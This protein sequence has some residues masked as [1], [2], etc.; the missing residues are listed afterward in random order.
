MLV[1]F[2]GCSG[3][4]SIDIPASV[5]DMGHITFSGC[6][7]LTS[8]NIPASVTS[9]GDCVFEGCSR[10]TSIDIPANVTTIGKNAFAGCSSL[11]SIDIPASVINIEE[12][13]LKDCSGLTLLN[14]QEGVI[15]IGKFRVDGCTS[16][17]RINIPASV[18]NI[19]YGA[20]ASYYST[21]PTRGV[22][23]IFC[24]GS[25]PVAL[26]GS[27]FSSYTITKG[28]LH[29]PYGTIEN[30]K[31]ADYW[32]RFANIVEFD[33]TDVEAVSADKKADAERKIYT[34]G[35]VWIAAPQKGLNIINGKKVVY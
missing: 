7:S 33:P 1:L 14:I 31:A 21:P 22:R 13:A 28:T 4:T 15:S 5:T 16:L 6:S 9:I 10:L 25:T 29:V 26:S 8:I 24:Y 35:G 27:I 12:Y 2:E 18:T 19:E 3:L 30:Y 11:T 34:L 20:F 17:R 32:K 23:D